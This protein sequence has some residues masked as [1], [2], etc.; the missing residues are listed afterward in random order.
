MC[1][2][3]VN[4]RAYTLT[5]SSS[6]AASFSPTRTNKHS[7]VI[8]QEF[9]PVELF[10]LEGKNRYRVTASGP[11]PKDMNN[12]AASL[13][14]IHEESNCCERIFCSVNRSLTLHVHEGGTRNGN[15]LFSMV[16]PF[17]LQG[18]ICCCR[19]TME[20][21]SGG[22]RLGRVE[23]PFEC[24][25]CLSCKVNQNLYNETNDLIFTTYGTLCQPGWCCPCFCPITFNVKNHKG[26]SDGQIIKG[27]QNLIELCCQ[28]NR[29]KVIFPPEATEQDK[30]LLIGASMLLDLEYFEQN[31]NQN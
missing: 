28:L 8:T 7:V 13:F 27:Y 14:Y 30:T 24:E 4:H 31:K 16:K 20:I 17:H 12:E 26:G 21:Y 2:A 5:L 9:A 18:C 19:P 29:F 10:G 25:V 3:G 1:Y 23:D 11:D 22:N 15:V 6:H